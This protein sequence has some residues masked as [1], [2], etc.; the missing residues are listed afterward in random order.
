MFFKHFPYCH[1][2]MR[3]QQNFCSLSGPRK[4]G[5]QNFRPSTQSLPLS[6]KRSTFLSQKHPAFPPM[7]ISLYHTHVSI[8]HTH[9]TSHHFHITVISHHITSIHQTHHTHI[10]PIS[11]QITPISP[12]ST[13]ISRHAT[14][15]L[16][17]IAFKSH[18]ITI[19][20]PYHVYHFSITSHI[21]RHT[22][23]VSRRNHT[24]ITT[25][26]THTSSHQFL[27]TSLSS[28]QHH[29]TSNV[30]QSECDHSHQNYITSTSDTSHPYHDIS[31]MTL[32]AT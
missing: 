16:Y 31:R 11:L 20:Y 32:Y 19:S 24:R 15:L 23:L 6:A 21:C 10:T 3:T 25:Q 9:I 26:P 8:H 2:L 29:I 17:H 30:T 28:V 4:L 5:I 14:S 1:I 27:I 7:P 22:T 18:H 13:F 12:Q